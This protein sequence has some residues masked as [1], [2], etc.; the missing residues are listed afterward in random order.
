MGFQKDSGYLKSCRLTYAPTLTSSLSEPEVTRIP[1]G[2]ISSANATHLAMVKFRRV[3]KY[4][5][6]MYSEELEYLQHNP[7]QSSVLSA[8]QCS[9]SCIIT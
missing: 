9:Q 6:T 8:V 4:S 5:P 3:G 1:P 2:H 7:T